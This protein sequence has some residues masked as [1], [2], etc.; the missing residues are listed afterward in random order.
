[1]KVIVFGCI[2]L[3]VFRIGVFVGARRSVLAT[4]GLLFCSA[5]RSTCRRFS[6]DHREKRSTLHSSSSKDPQ[7]QK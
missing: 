3:L 7:F 1:M 4:L 2:I 5:E 6:R